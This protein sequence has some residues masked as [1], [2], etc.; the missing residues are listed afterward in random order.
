MNEN[1][2]RLILLLIGAMIILGMLW[3]G[4]RRKREHFIA[5][6]EQSPMQDHPE[7]AIEDLFD[8]HHEEA[9]N[10]ENDIEDEPEE[11]KVEAHDEH[12][13]DTE[14]DDDIEV[15]QL[16][17]GESDDDYF[18][19]ASPVLQQPQSAKPNFISIRVMASHNKSFSG[20]E[21]LQTFLSNN[22]DYGENK[23]FHRYADQEKSEKLF[24]LAS[25]SEPGDFE[26]SKIGDFVSDGLI[27]YMN[28]ND[29]NDPLDVFN[30]MLET[31]KD[32]AHHLHGKLMSGQNKP[33]L[34]ETTKEIQ[35]TL[36]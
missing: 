22:L 5:V 25:L 17:E 12:V 9:I 30:E 35:K 10:E 29:H 15:E 1:T 33:W 6:R 14:E 31:A 13:E 18:E 20:Y 19:Q 4:L 2:I 36:K 34:E 32:L 16:E 28:P 24:S 11:D 8:I 23:L 7:K 27:L 3:D 21:L 26:L